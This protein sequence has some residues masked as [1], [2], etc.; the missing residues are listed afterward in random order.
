MIQQ[1]Q[2]M[3]P[4]HRWAAHRASLAGWPAS[5]TTSSA[6]SWCWWT[7]SNPTAVHSIV[8][9]LDLRP[10]NSSWLLPSDSTVGISLKIPWPVATFFR[11]ILFCVSGPIYFSL[12]C[13]LTV[14]SFVP[15]RTFTTRQLPEGKSCKKKIMITR[16]EKIMT[17]LQSTIECPMSRTQKTHYCCLTVI[18]FGHVI[19]PSAN[20]QQLKNTL[21]LSFLL[22]HTLCRPLRIPWHSYSCLPNLTPDKDYGEKLCRK[23]FVWWSGALQRCNAVVVQLN[24]VYHCNLTD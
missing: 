7:Y 16:N 14:A 1:V 19:T 17:S 24:R 6:S 8:I 12:Q 21:C 5:I 10:T 15:I 18:A 23:A 11:C 9:A 20:K 2:S 4:L 13:S 22:A 3:Q